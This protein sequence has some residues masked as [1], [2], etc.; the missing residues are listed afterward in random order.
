MNHRRDRT[1]RLTEGF[2]GQGWDA[3]YVAFFDCFN[4]Q[5]FFEAHEVLEKLWLAERGGPR[6]LFYKGL[7]QVA[8]AF[9]HWQKQRLQPAAAL[10]RLAE[11]NLRRYP[12]RYEALDNSLLQERIGQWL[13]G[14]LAAEPV[15]RPTLLLYLC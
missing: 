2:Q 5:R 11:S 13:R 14:V 8:G 1:A 10:L 7:I 4:H 12:A 6:D 3:H 9:V 15:P